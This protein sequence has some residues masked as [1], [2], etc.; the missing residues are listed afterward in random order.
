[1]A[2]AIGFA[3]GTAG[4]FGVSARPSEFPLGLIVAM[5][6]CAAILIALRQ[7]SDD[8]W[9]VVLGAVGMYGAILIFSLRGPGGSVVLADVWQSQVWMYGAG[10]IVLLIAAWPD[11]SR[12]R[13]ATPER[14][15]ASASQT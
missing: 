12:L 2:V 13:T 9:G 6:G 14:P 7:L 3:F 1:M 15:N 8:R 10:L 11:L 5:L 4:T